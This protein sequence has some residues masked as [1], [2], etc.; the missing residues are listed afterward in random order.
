MIAR[1]PRLDR[2]LV[3]AIPTGERLED[4][5]LRAGL[6][7]SASQNSFAT[8]AVLQQSGLERVVR[9]ERGRGQGTG[10]AGAVD[11]FVLFGRSMGRSQAA[12]E[13]QVSFVVLL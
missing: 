13:L 8:A 9:R 5:L 4:Y 1:D 7:K 6:R 12:V 11:D 2:S 10:Q 3:I